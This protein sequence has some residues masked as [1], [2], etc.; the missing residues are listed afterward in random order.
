MSALQGGV[1]LPRRLIEL[2]GAEPEVDRA[3]GAVG[4][5]VVRARTAVGLHVPERPP[6]NRQQLV[7]EGGLER[8]QVVLAHADQGRGGR[9]VRAALRRQGDSRRGRH[10]DEAG[11]LV[12][13]VVERVEAALDERVVD[14][15]DGDE[16]ARRTVDGTGPPRR[17]SGTGCAPRSRARRAAPSA[18]PPS[19]GTSRPAPSRTCPPAPCG[20]RGAAGSPSRRGWWR[21][22][23]PERW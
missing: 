21:P 11:V 12:E 3:A 19:A 15:P 8:R 10:E 4:E 18:R 6:E 17:A 2:A 22:S 16:D 5:Q 20:G 14:G 7:R 23:R 9:L 1:D 13:R